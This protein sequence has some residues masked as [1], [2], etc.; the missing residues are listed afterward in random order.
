MRFRNNTK[1]LSSFLVIVFVLSLGLHNHVFYFGSSLPDGVY[2]TESGYPGHN[3]EFCS[4]CR[5]NGNLRQT[6]KFTNIDFN[7]SSQLIAFVNTDLLIPSSYYQL[8]FSPR[9]PPIT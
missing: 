3:S 7:K 1:I 5:L 9:S 2:K 6:D 8:N 4:A